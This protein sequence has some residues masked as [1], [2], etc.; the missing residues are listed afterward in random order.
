MRKTPREK[1][2]A[3]SKEIRRSGKDSSKQNVSR[4]ESN[5]NSGER[6]PDSHL[7][8]VASPEKKQSFL[9]E[10]AKRH[11]N[12][13]VLG[14]LQKQRKESSDVGPA[15][16]QHEVAIPEH[17]DEVTRIQMQLKKGRPLDG[18][19]RQ[20]MESGL[21]QSLGN[22]EIHTDE[23]AARLASQQ[24]ARAFAV[25]EHVVFGAGEYQPGTLEGD[26]ILAHELA[27]V[28]QQRG[29]QPGKTESNASEASLEQDANLAVMGVARQR[30]GSIQRA[31]AG[32]PQLAGARM[33]S[34]LHI[35]RCPAV[36]SG[37]SNEEKY[38]AVKD[39]LSKAEDGFNA[40]HYVLSD[41]ASEKAKK[42]SETFG[43]INGAIDKVELGI[44]VYDVVKSYND[45]SRYDPKENPKEFAQAAGK[46]L[47]S[48][49]KIMQ[50]SHLPL[51]SN[52]GEF[53]AEAG[54]FFE[55]MRK[56]LDPNE[57]YKGRQDWEEAKKY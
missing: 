42:V 7:L 12:Q 6:K 17:V 35:A 28:A 29:A 51:V 5:S 24:Q 46:F 27:H 19:I 34:G 25:G 38:E 26:A 45:F 3:N 41:E 53:L 49:G 32:F 8:E 2:P 48:A 9:R 55:N 47:A 22:V 39:A 1:S 30:F 36:S 44:E 14:L 31:L 13:A 10:V 15:S 37:K 56:K 16:A 50:R 20:E 4:H 33:R 21:G 23:Q 52:Y 40:A 43:K 11:G 54:D 57:R 18:H